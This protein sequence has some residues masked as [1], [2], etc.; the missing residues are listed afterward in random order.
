[1]SAQKKLEKVKKANDLRQLHEQEIR[2]HPKMEEKVKMQRTTI[3]MGDGGVQA[4][5]AAVL[6]EALEE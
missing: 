5:E 6:E 4:I 2:K 1:M 3:T